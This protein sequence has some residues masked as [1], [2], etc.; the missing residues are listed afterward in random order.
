MQRDS[1]ATLVGE[2]RACTDRCIRTLGTGILSHGSNGQLRDRLANG[3]LATEEFFRQLR[4]LLL[5]VST[6]VLGC[7]RGILAQNLQLPEFATE[8]LARP[9]G[10]ATRD[11]G[12][13]WRKVQR[14]LLALWQGD[15]ALGIAASSVGLFDPEY[16]GEVGQAALSDAV[17]LDLLTQISGV[18]AGGGQRWSMPA[19]GQLLGYMHEWLLERQLCLQSHPWAIT[20]AASNEHERR[21][22]GSYFTPPELV[23]HILDA[24]LEPRLAACLATADGARQRLLQ[25]RIVDPACGTG[26][27]LC[28]AA[29]RVAMRLDH[30][31]DDSRRVSVRESP[32]GPS[33]DSLSLVVSQCIYGVDIGPMAVALCQIAL[34]FECN[35]SPA[36]MQAVKAHVR[37][38]NAIF[39]A[40]PGYEQRGVSDGVFDARERG[41]AEGARRLKR[42]NR[43][44]RLEWQKSRGAQTHESDGQ[45][46]TRDHQC[47]LADLWCS[48][49]VWP[50]CGDAEFPTDARFREVSKDPQQLELWRASVAEFKR[51][52]Q[53]FH[54]HLEFPDVFAPDGKNSALNVGDGFD[55]VLGNPPWVAHAGRSTQRLHSGVKRFLINQYQSF[56]G[57]PTTHGA[58]VE[59]A[60][61]LLRTGGQIGF[62]IPASVA[63]LDGYAGAR[64][65]HDTLCEITTPLTDYGE[66]RF[67]GVTQP[68]IGLISLRTSS[69]RRAEERGQPWEIERTDIDERGRNLLRRLVLM[70]TLPAEIF[71]ERGFQSTPIT[72]CHFVEQQQ[73][74]GPYTLPLLEGA[75]IRECCRTPACHHASAE[76][77]KHGLRP[78]EE[79]A[80]VCLLVRQTARY[81]IVARSNGSAF[82]NSLLAV[83]ETPEWPWALLLALMNSSLI[84]WHHYFRYRDARQPILPQLKV[85]HLRSIP[86]PISEDSGA[87]ET[88]ERLGLL[89]GERND[90]IRSQERAAIDCCVA[91]LYGLS[92]EEHQLVSQWQASGIH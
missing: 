25:L 20:L 28:A 73:P 82:R 53:F 12:A 30:L 66:G 29:R 80:K 52:F 83:M 5:Q 19:D 1:H 62:V 11:D 60:A 87:R 48:A 32:S 23:E 22:S 65:A 38:G 56:T 18:L 45:T 4:G 55:C 33:Q 54:W 79:F 9:L 42:R 46:R 26:V 16:T 49:F 34:W 85:G 64:L 78:L 90:G 88:L 51:R 27:F 15:P 57:Y 44:E 41:E 74:G 61:R 43:A 50:I 58:F 86:A 21:T 91:S 31:N 71:G 8:V 63:D 36:V 47:A 77:L 76:L 67:A 89:L 75:D 39:G 13:R 7:T 69:G 40:F 35:A 14:I 81:P 72:R 59:L 92:D 70:A 10:D 68:C 24:C 17:A 6:W 84:R 37:C 2:L 3:S